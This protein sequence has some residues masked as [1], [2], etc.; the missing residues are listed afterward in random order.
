MKIL[1]S[2]G[3]AASVLVLLF[4]SVQPSSSQPVKGQS[5]ITSTADTTIAVSTTVE[6]SCNGHVAFGLPGREDQLLCRE[7]YAVGYD[8]ERK[9]P[10]WVAYLITKE[11]VEKKYKRSNK[12]K[13]DKDLPENSRATLAD[14]KGSGYDRGHMAPAAT[15]DFSE[16]SMQES[17][18]LSNM[19]PQLPGFNRQGWKHLETY[20]RD[21]AEVRGALYVVT[22]A[23]FESEVVTI[24]DHVNIPSS[25]YKVIFAP[26][27]SDAIAFIVPHRKIAKADL[28]GFIVTIDQ[29][30]QRTGLDFI[31]ALS[32]DLESD[33][34]DNVAL[35]W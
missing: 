21:W 10:S 9:V 27:Q 31:S 25:F 15:V 14:Y 26:D 3:L 17:F 29:V 8:Y 11:S 34:E 30:E 5:V 13:V 35:M 32:D 7:G 2:I 4:F 22:G 6:W 16:E 18:L 19:T 12:F 28:P 1:L 20:V 24:G 23:L 33:I